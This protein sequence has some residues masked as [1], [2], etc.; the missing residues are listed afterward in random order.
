M[1][2]HPTIEEILKYEEDLI[3]AVEHKVSDE[4][5]PEKKAMLLK[6]EVLIKGRNVNAF[7]QLLQNHIVSKSILKRIQEIDD[8]LDE[9][10]YESKSSLS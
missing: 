1:Q 4:D 6:L 2:E 5:N 8:A 9:L 3:D 7:V 10:S